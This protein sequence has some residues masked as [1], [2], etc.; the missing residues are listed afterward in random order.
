MKY[1]AI[2]S[3]LFYSLNKGPAKPFRINQSSSYLI[4]RHLTTSV[5]RKAQEQLEQF[6]QNEKIDSSRTVA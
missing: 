2:S 1:R 6:F 3:V 4:Q 5:F